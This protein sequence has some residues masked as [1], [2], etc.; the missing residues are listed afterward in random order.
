MLPTRV[1]VVEQK[2]QFSCC[3]AQAYDIWGLHWVLYSQSI[4]NSDE[5]TASH[6]SLLHEN[7]L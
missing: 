2:I 6:I 1:K 7:K 3:N 5:C 4:K